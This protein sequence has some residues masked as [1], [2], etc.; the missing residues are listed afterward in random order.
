MKKYII[1]IN[2]YFSLFLFSPVDM[3]FRI[4]GLP[5][6]IKNLFVYRTMSQGQSS[7]PLTFSALF[8]V[9]TDRYL[10]AGSIKG[11]YFLQDLHVAKLI[12][13]EKPS[14]H[15]DV[16]S[17]LDGFISHLLIFLKV[18]YVD[19][20]DLPISLENL[21]YSQGS[22]T[23]LPFPD[24][25]LNSLSSL[26][27]LEHIGLGRYGDP[28]DP[29]GYKKA[30]SELQRVLAPGGKLY[31]SVPVGK[32]KVF[33]DAHRVF[34]PETIISLFDEV[35]LKE[36][37]LIDDVGEEVKTQFTFELARECKYGCGIF[38]FQKN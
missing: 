9:L 26:H 5:T 35:Q 33:F 37:Y 34:W 20:R 10:S 38:V 31:L 19:I 3:F 21:V 16:G 6:F 12:H 4:S 17:R 7:F 27:V 1:S 11:H 15:V 36:F 25:S 23:K 14:Q 32:E 2:H 24:A 13:K 29:E 28:I 8:P 22:I 18:I 30:I